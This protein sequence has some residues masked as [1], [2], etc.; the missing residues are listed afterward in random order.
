M[1]TYRQHGPQPVE[2]LFDRI[3]GENGI[4]HRHTGVN[5]NRL[6]RRHVP[7]LALLASPA[8]PEVISLLRFRPRVAVAALFVTA[9]ALMG[10]PAVSAGSFANDL[11]V[12]VS[13]ASPIPAACI[14]DIDAPASSV[15]HY[16][17]EVEPHVM[18]DPSDPDVLIGAWQQDRWNDGGARGLVT[19]TSLDGGDSWTT[20]AD[21]KSSV[22]TGGTP[23]N[24]GNY[25]RASD[26][27]IAISP[28]GTAYLMSLSVDTNPGGFGIAPNAMLAMRSTDHG[29]TWEDPVTLIRDTNVTV[30]NDKNTITADPNDSNFVYAVWDRLASPTSG[31]ASPV[32]FENSIDFS[33]DIWF[34]RT[35]DGGDSWEPARKIYKA[36]QIAQTI[37]NLIVVEP[38][39]VPGFNGEL[40]NVFTQA[41]FRQAEHGSRGIFLA[42]IRSEDHGVTWTKGESLI[43]RFF[44]GFV[45]DPDDGAF[46]RT[47]D[48]NPEAA[49]DMNTGAIYVVWQDSSMAPDFT[50][51]GALRGGSAIALSR[52]TDGGRTWSAPIK[53]N[54]TPTSRPA[55][56]QQ[57]F[58]PMVAVGDDGTVS[59]FYYDFRNNTAD[60]GATTPTD[61]FVAHCHATAEDCTDPASW[62]EE[63]RVTDASFDSRTAPIARGF[64]LGDYVGLGTDGTDFFPFFVQSSAADKASVF[65][66]RTG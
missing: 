14:G 42:A 1:E 24:G 11:L 59:V 26:P 44:R 57:A 39:G 32:A 18:V 41:R 43:S 17:T 13:G 25:Q 9:L 19:A 21:T 65:V 55:G 36:G 8:A 10:A 28:D 48:I 15:N 23:A 12:Q 47:G 2:V 5:P 58:D 34:A 60:G 20:N 30:L 62:D 46:H 16:N 4:S 3:C 54:A 29:L 35:T 37:G 61:A 51:G 38:T 64:F 56:D 66:R 22:C 7:R 52:S 63:T 53:V 49:V 31:N 6:D 40:V 33:G 45:A 27:W 50:A